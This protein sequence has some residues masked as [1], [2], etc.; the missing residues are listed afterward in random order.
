MT[1]PLPWAGLLEA[2]GEARFEEIRTGLAAAH[3]DAGDRDAFL[4]DAAVGRV[5]RELVPP[6]APAEAVT[7]YAAFLQAMY[8]LWAAGAPPKSVDRERLRGLLAAPRSAPLTAPDGTVAYIQLPEQMVWAAAAPDAA[9]EP[10]DGL[11]VITGPS[12]LRTIALLGVRPGREGF[13]TIE[14]A[15][16]LPPGPLEAR[17]DGA[18]PFS[19]V[20]P[21]GE[22]MG[23]LSVTSPLELVWLALLAWSATTD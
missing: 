21:A 17:A 2:L 10:I 3:T 5:L 22:R 19:T 9:H 12:G 13:T 11:V 4:L 23:F 8:L 7:S 1:R 14:A 18:A 6:D 15:A 20:L 16:P